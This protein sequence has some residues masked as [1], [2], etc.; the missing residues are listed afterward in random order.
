MSHQSGYAASVEAAKASLE[1]ARAALSRDVAQ[2]VTSANW[3]DFL[4]DKYDVEAL[5]QQISEAAQSK[6]WVSSLHASADKTRAQQPQRGRPSKSQAKPL[7]KA[8]QQTSADENGG[9][10]TATNA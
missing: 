1:A 5:I 8:R 9:A 6:D 4:R 2:A 3:S 7:Q 10:A